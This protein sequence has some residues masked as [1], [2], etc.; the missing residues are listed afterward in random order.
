[1]AVQ[2][3]EVQRFRGSEVQRFRGSEVQRFRGSGVQGFR[4]SEVQRL[5]SRRFDGVSL[6][7]SPVIPAKAESNS[8]DT[9]AGYRL[10]APLRS[11]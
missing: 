8:F 6:S 3:S 1:M 5:F 11:E 10:L 7:D 9:F 2:G 4:G